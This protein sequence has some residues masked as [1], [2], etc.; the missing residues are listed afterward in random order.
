MNI[1]QAFEQSLKNHFEHLQESNRLERYEGN[2]EWFGASSVGMCVKKNFYKRF[3]VVEEPRMITDNLIIH[4]G[5]EIHEIIQDAVIAEYGIEGAIAEVEL[6]DETFGIRGFADIILTDNNPPVIIDIKTTAAFSFRLMFGR[7]KKE[8]PKPT[9]CMQVATYGYMYAKPH[10]LNEYNDIELKILYINRDS[11]K[12]KWVDIPTAWIDDALNYFASLERWATEITDPEKL[13]L[14]V[15]DMTLN[16]PAMPSWEC[17][18]S[19]GKI[20]CP[21][22]GYCRENKKLKFHKK[23]GDDGKT[24]K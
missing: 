12:Y 23:E 14:L 5:N 7:D 9:H 10:D 21:Y 3:R 17:K 24:D 18:S 22:Y 4:T 20:Y 16:V 6:S 19:S 1:E 8:P 13:N 11:G 2:E 15:P